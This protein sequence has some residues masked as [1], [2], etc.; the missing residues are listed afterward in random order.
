M[1]L[2]RGEATQLLE[3]WLSVAPAG[4]GPDPALGLRTT[5]DLG[6]VVWDQ[7]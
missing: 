2:G 5:A 7:A 6:F 3:Q 1:T 4:G